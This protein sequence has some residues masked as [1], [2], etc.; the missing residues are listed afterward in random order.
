MPP[1]TVACPHLG[2]VISRTL[3][4]KNPVVPAFIDACTSVIERASVGQ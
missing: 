1:Q 3:G 4:P 2:S